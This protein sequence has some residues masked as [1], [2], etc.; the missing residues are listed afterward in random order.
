MGAEG[1]P[2]QRHH[3]EVVNTDFAREIINDPVR[4]AQMENRS[5]LGRFGEPE[6]TAGIVHFLAS[7]A[8]AYSRGQVIVAD[9]GGMLG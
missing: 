7:D 2:R 4:R 5:P 9:G 8:S 6:D 3:A 1:D